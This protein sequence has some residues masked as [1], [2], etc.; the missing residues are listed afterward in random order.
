MASRP[1]V[2]LAEIDMSTLLCM[3][4]GGE[5][6][7]LRYHPGVDPLL[8]WYVDGFTVAY[9]GEDVGTVELVLPTVD[10]DLPGSLIVRT[11]DGGGALLDT[12]KVE[13]VRF[14]E[15]RVHA[16]AEPAPFDVADVPVH[17]GYQASA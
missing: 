15:R 10:G 14:T 7:V 4:R 13:A 6:R 2:W 16:A 12:G 1:R 9:G 17:A 11:P 8:L 5:R 3:R